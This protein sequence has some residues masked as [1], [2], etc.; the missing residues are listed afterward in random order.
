L[1]PAALKDE[2]RAV[3]VLTSFIVDTSGHVD[4]STLRLVKPADPL[5]AH[6]VRVALWDSRFVPAEISGRKV[7]QLVQQS[8]LFSP[9]TDSVLFED[10]FTT[11]RGMAEFGPEGSGCEG[12]Y[13]SGGF[14]FRN[15]KTGDRGCYNGFDRV[16]FLRPP[17]RIE[18]TV[19]KLA[20]PPNTF[21]G[22]CFA[23]A[24][25]YATA[26][27]FQITDSGYARLVRWENEK[28]VVIDQAKVKDARTGPNKTNRLSV[29]LRGRMIIMFVNGT[30]A[31]RPYAAPDDIGGW[32]CGYLGTPGQEAQFDNL[33]VTRLSENP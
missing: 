3:E 10:D 23:A 12:H 6:A 33:K 13:Q 8:F 27:A 7:P 30:Q 2:E 15:S 32:I 16:D 11:S 18:M 1:Y 24:Q 20:G 19:Q 31:L 9:P 4:T 14:V 28:D 22:F 29:E 17:V 25:R 5:F 21:I 26:Y